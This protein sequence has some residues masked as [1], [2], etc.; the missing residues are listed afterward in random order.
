MTFLELMRR[1]LQ[2]KD[3][4]I[5]PRVTFNTD[6]TVNNFLYF[7][8]R[9][10]SIHGAVDINYGDGVNPNGQ[11]PVYAPVS[12]EV[13]PLTVNNFGSVLIRSSSDGTLHRI[14]HL[15]NIA[16]NA[17]AQVTAGV[18]ELGRMSNV[19]PAEWGTLAVHVHYEIYLPDADGWQF[20]DQRIDPLIYWTPGVN[21]N[22]NGPNATGLYAYVTPVNDV[23]GNGT[24]DDPAPGTAPSEIGAVVREGGRSYLKVGVNTPHTRPLELRLQFTGAPAGFRV[25][26]RAGDFAVQ[27]NDT[28]KAAYVTLP[29]TLNQSTPNVST[30]IELFMLEKDNDPKNEFLTYTVIA[31]YL[32]AN[33]QWSDFN[34]TATLFTPAGGNLAVLEAAIRPSL[35]C[36]PRL[37]PIGDNGEDDAPVYRPRYTLKHAA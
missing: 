16:V 1:M 25:V 35:A 9:T 32:D 20:T 30:I 8:S 28:G 4:V 33:N 12:G 11:Y 15:S 13:I 10:N 7:S 3:G 27:W 31:G 2:P 22:A 23:N 18:T 36:D 5:D 29:A 14:S 6:G 17:N 26:D 19:A 37:V 24:I 34:Q 21:P